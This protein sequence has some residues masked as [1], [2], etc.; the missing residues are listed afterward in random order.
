MLHHRSRDGRVISREWRGTREPQFPPT[1]VTASHKYFCLVE[2]ETTILLHSSPPLSLSRDRY[3]ILNF[4]RAT[5]ADSQSVSGSQAGIRARRDE[6]NRGRRDTRQ[7]CPYSFDGIFRG[8]WKTRKVANISLPLATAC[9]RL[10]PSSFRESLR[11]DCSQRACT[12]ENFS[13]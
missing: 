2:I 10:F 3:C 4:L 13:V 11:F 9:Q 6:R 5:K 1:I 12:L 7:E 8:E